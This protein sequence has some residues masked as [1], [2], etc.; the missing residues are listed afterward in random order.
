[1]SSITIGSFGTGDSGT[2]TIGANSTAVASGTST[3]IPVHGNLDGQFLEVAFTAGNGFGFNGLTLEATVV[4][5]PSAL[6][7]LSPLVLSMLMQTRRRSG[8]G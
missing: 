3:T 1:M 2:L 7:L 4:P 5:E 8:L 6:V